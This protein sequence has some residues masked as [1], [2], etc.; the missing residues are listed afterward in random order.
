L[1]P[2]LVGAFTRIQSGLR[3]RGGRMGSGSFMA[4]R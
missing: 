3:S 1:K 2:W 4:A